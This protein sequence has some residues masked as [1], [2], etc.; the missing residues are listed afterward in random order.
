[1]PRVMDDSLVIRAPVPSREHT[2]RHR[3]PGNRFS[4]A[5]LAPHVDALAYAR[6]DFVMHVADFRLEPVEMLA[7]FAVAARIAS[8]LASST[9]NRACTVPRPGFT[10]SI[11]AAW[12]QTM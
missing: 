2:P 11:S 6:H 10:N 3:V 1:M 4:V 12:S 9:S 5:R 7:A 8:R